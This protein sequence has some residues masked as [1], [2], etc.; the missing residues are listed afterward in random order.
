MA[1]QQQLAMAGGVLLLILLAALAAT[2]F[3]L[4]RKA[5]S[6]EEAA[7]ADARQVCSHLAKGKLCLSATAGGCMTCSALRSMANRSLH[8]TICQCTDSA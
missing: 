7:A 3:L 1:D 4:T 8:A 2:A 6:Q 5:E